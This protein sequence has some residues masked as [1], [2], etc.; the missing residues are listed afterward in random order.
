MS[1]LREGIR[2]EKAQEELESQD[3]FRQISFRPWVA[4]GRYDESVIFML[5]VIIQSVDHLRGLSLG[6][7]CS[8]SLNNSNSTLVSLV[9]LHFCVSF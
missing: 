5:A 1:K 3:R 8:S 6:Y 7:L 2:D 9:D 4:A